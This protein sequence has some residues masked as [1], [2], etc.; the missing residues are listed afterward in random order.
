MAQQKGLR[1]LKT[2]ST[3]ITMFNAVLREQNPSINLPSSQITRC[4]FQEVDMGPQQAQVCRQSIENTEHWETF[5]GP[6]V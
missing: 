4:T 6:E 5:C 2:R 1:W 3:A